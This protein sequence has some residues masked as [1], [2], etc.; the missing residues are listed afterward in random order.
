METS[1]KF[2]IFRMDFNEF[3]KK[4]RDRLRDNMEFD[5]LNVHPYGDYSEDSESEE[6]ESE[7]SGEGGNS[8]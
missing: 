2:L 8:F 3:Y 5:D 1:L 4:N 6:D 7:E